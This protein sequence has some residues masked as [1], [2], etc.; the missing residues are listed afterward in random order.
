ME[1]SRQEYWSGLPFPSPGLKHLEVLKEENLGL[2]CFCSPYPLYHPL[3]SEGSSGSPGLNY[4]TG[5]GEGQWRRW[6]GEDINC[7][8]I[9]EQCTQQS[10]ILQ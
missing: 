10:E 7:M 5:L 9:L 3:H 2:L 6:L 8:G 1:F 4:Y